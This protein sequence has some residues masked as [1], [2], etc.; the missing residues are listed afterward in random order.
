QT[1]MSPNDY[2]GSRVSLCEDGKYRWTY[3]LDMLKN[4]SILFVLLKIFGILLSIPLLI[5][6][7]SAAANND[8]QKIWD[9]FIKIWLIVMVVFFVIILISYLIVV[10]M[11][12]GKYVVN[13]TMDEKRLIHEQVPVQYERARKVGLLAALV[14]IFAKRPAAAGAGAL[15]A[16]RDTSVSVFDKVRRVKP[17]RGQNLIKVNQSLERNQVYVPD[18]D[19][20]F[21]LDFIRKHCPNAK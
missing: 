8:W 15:A 11:N 20:D 4:P 7:I 5:A 21:V 13:F 1:V 18:E 14:G 12:G 17:R 6:L 16:S 3:P 10:W 2:S 9:G 19:F